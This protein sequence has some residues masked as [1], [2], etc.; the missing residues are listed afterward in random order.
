MISRKSG[1]RFPRKCRSRERDRCRRLAPRVR[2]GWV[3]PRRGTRMRE[4]THC[5]PYCRPSRGLFLSRPMASF[6][7]CRRATP[8][9]RRTSSSA[10]TRP[11]ARGPSGSRG[12]SR[13]KAST[14]SP[15]KRGTSA[16]RQ[17]SSRSPKCGNQGQQFRQR[18]AGFGRLAR[19]QSRLRAGA[20]D[21]AEVAGRKP[22]E[23]AARPAEFGAA[24]RGVGV[25]T[26]ERG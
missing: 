24:P 8:L 18:A 22:S 17:T 19:R 6:V 20:G 13:R 9:R 26:W 12:T 23:D 1:R 11:T 7:A 5:C 16:P 14:A 25:M 10:T 3:A 2:R 15:S 21:L 4:T